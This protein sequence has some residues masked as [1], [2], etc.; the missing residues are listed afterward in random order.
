MTRREI[1]VSIEQN[2]K[3]PGVGP[4]ARYRLKLGGWFVVRAGGRAELTAKGVAYML[5]KRY[6]ERKRT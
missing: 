4:L 6:H 1:L 5:N 3:L 2:G